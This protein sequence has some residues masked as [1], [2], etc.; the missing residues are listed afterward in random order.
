MLPAILL[1]QILLLPPIATPLIPPRP[2]PPHPP[3]PAPRPPP[4]LLQPHGPHEPSPP[5]PR[6]GPPPPRATT[7]PASLPSSARTPPPG[8][9]RPRSSGAVGDFRQWGAGKRTPGGLLRAGGRRGRGGGAVGA[10]DLGA[11]GSAF[12]AGERERNVLAKTGVGPRRDWLLSVVLET[13]EG[14]GGEG[15]VS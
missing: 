4:V 11:R 7:R 2:H 1:I 5:P 14:P 12:W 13:V 8:P 3:H 6:P 9:S 10:G 15:S